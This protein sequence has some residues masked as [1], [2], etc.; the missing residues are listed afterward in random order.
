MRLYRVEVMCNNNWTGVFSGAGWCMGT[1][2]KN[3]KEF[4]GVQ[5]LPDEIEFGM[6][7]HIC[8]WLQYP[9]CEGQYWFTQAGWDRFQKS[10]YSLN[11]KTLTILEYLTSIRLLDT[12]GEPRQ[13]R[14][15]RMKMRPNKIK[16]VAYKDRHQFCLSQKF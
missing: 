6:V 7:N 3:L 2:I 13:Y 15:R 16:L 8:G 9:D 10:R 11:G 5:F 1:T 14:V 12:E 4:F